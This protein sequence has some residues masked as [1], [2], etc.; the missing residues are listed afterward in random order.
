MCGEAVSE[1][2]GDMNPEDHSLALKF[3]L[4]LPEVMSCASNEV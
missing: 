3:T 2:L 1:S 4:S